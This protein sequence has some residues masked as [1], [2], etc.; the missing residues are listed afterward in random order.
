MESSAHRLRAV[1]ADDA[2]FLFCLFAS[3]RE[4]EF[5]QVPWTAEQKAHFLRQQF[6]AQTRSWSQEYPDA[7]FDLVEVDGHAAGRLYVH[8]AER[9]Y[10]IVDI[11]LLPNHSGRGIGTTLLQSVIVEA[12]HVGKPVS[13]HVDVF[14]PARRLYERLG[15]AQVEDRGVYLLMVRAPSVAVRHR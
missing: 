3:T 11:A 13:L 4:R 15:F 6:D 9:D 1:T 14:N 2:E 10:R 12:E 8:R 5:A 7:S